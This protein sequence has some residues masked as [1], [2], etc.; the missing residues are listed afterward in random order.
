MIFSEQIFND[1]ETGLLVII[2]YF[3][4]KPADSFNVIGASALGA[5]YI[6]SL[7]T[8]TIEQIFYYR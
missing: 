2:E 8:K 4:L 7:S 3:G 6:N 1:D 5:L